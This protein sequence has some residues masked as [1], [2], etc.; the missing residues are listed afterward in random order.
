MRKWAVLPGV[1]VIRSRSTQKSPLPHL[2]RG[3]QGGIG[4]TRLEPISLVG[5]GQMI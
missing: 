3:D 4:I 2:L 1:E 5:A